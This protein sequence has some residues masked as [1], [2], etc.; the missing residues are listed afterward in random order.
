M[1]WLIQVF[2]ALL[3]KRSDRQFAKSS[4]PNEGQA[5]HNLLVMVLCMSLA[6]LVLKVLA[7]TEHNIFMFGN[8]CQ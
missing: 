7:K 6:N 5:T 4:Q 8:P 3:Q 2:I 1:L